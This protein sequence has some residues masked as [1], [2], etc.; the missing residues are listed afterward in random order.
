MQKW[1][2]LERNMSDKEI[3]ARWYKNN[4]ITIW[5]AIGIV[6]WIAFRTYANS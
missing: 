4:K 5:F 3:L 1:G 6:I 2:F